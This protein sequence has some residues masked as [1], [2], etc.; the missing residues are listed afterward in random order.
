MGSLYISPS[1][2][3][4]EVTIPPSKSHTLRALF[5]A[6]LGTGKTVIENPLHSTDSKAMIQAITQFGAKVSLADGDLHVEGG[7]NPAE[8]IIDAGNSGL[9]YRFIAGIAALLPSYTLITGDSSIRTRRPITPLLGALNQL[10]G[11]AESARGDGHAPILIKGPIQAGKCTLSG[12]DSQ[13]VSA[14]LNAAS[15]LEGVTEIFVEEPKE[16]PWIDLTLGWLARLGAN[17]EHADYT[18]YRVEG[19][20]AYEG[21]SYKVPGDFSTAAF[22]LAAALVTQ[23]PLTIHGLDP[24]D[25]QGDKV[26]IEILQE[27]KANIHWESDQ[28]IVFPSPN[29]EGISIDLDRGIDMLPILAVLGCFAKGTTTLYNGAIARKKE[30]DRISSIA[31]ELKKMGASI[32]ERPDGLIIYQSELKGAKL[33][34]HADHRI[35]MSLAVAALGAKGSSE[36]SGAEWIGKTYPGFANDI[37]KLGGKIELDPLRV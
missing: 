24:S 3:Q 31:T 2:L 30:T 19:G 10:G 15:F 5:F 23:S 29:L 9:V 21:F 22:P 26:L 11:V 20:L 17:V 18:H 35:G 13:P 7:F 25:S 36:L 33:D 12:S 37:Q 16:T 4:G 6:M 1:T 32:E 27:M 8:N 28:L 34:A 14:L